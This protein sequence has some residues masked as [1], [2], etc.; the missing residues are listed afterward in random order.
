MHQ[1]WIGKCLVLSGRADSAGTRVHGGG[2][3]LRQLGD[4]AGGVCSDGSWLPVVI[5]SLHPNELLGS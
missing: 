3:V 2:G 1:S 5:C 4:S